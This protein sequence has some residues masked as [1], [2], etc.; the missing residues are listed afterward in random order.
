MRTQTA[1]LA[2]VNENLDKVYGTA[3]AY[4]A[5]S[6]VVL[7]AIE[8]LTDVEEAKVIIKKINNKRYKTGR[9]GVNVPYGHRFF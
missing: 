2:E 8:R 6:M 4:E 7:W 5:T 1:I 9:V 3:N